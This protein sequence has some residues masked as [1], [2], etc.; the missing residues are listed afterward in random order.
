MILF[1]SLVQFDV[2]KL[3]LS[4]IAPG[5]LITVL[6]VGTAVALDAFGEQT[7][8]ARA[9]FKKTWASF[10]SALPALAMPGVVL[11]GIYAGAF[12]PTEAAAIAIAYVLVLSFIFER[13]K[14]KLSTII[15]SA[16]QAVITATVI[17]I[18]LGGATIFANGLTFANIPQEFTNF[19]LGL[20]VSE[21]LT[22]AVILLLFMLLGTVLDPVPI[23][24]ITVPIIFPVVQGLGYST[25]HFAILTVTCMMIAQ[26]TPPVGMSLFA[27]SGVFRVPLGVVVRGA[28]PYLGA[29]VV[30][31]LILWL[32]PAI[33]TFTE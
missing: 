20:P 15:H 10:L 33:S 29:L 4:G 9:G 21:H 19:M 18:I 12:T 30:A 27:L 17:F 16:E 31:L 13:D 8:P 23:L 7:L 14:F 24:Y 28:L 2:A 1:A 22:M 5:L 26:V 25:T 3:F 11:G 6:L 32:V